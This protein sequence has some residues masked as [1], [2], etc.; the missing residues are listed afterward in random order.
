[1][2]Q[3]RGVLGRVVRVL[4]LMVLALVAISALAVTWRVLG[5]IGP[6]G[7]PAMV[8]ATAGAAALGELVGGGPYGAGIWTN[9]AAI[10]VDPDT[11]A[12]KRA[13]GGAIGRAVA[14]TTAAAVD[15]RFR[16]DIAEIIV[17]D[18][19]LSDGDWSLVRGYLKSH[20]NY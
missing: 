20:W 9:G 15:W 6:W 11:T 14:M 16:G 13:T 7:W 18:S 4:F 5:R 19:A 10:Q 2:A 8:L 12:L 3:R 1:M 17:Y